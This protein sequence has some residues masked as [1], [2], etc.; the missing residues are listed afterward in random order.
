MTDHDFDRSVAERIR[1]YEARVAGASVPGVDEPPPAPRSSRLAWT[2]VVAAGGVA[3]GFALALA[4]NARIGPPVGQPTSSPTPTLEVSESGSPSPLPSEPAAATAPPQATG[5]LAVSRDGDVVLIRPDGTTVQQL[6]DDTG[7]TEVPVAWLLDGSALVVAVTADDNPYSSMLRLVSADG[8]ESTELGVV[9]P[10]YGAP[11]TSPDGQRI[12]FGGDGGASGGIQVLDLADGNLHVMTDDG[13][14]AP[15]WSPD[16]ELIAYNAADGS[17]TDVHVV[18]AD[19]SGPPAALAPDPAQ[20][21]V[22]RWVVSDGN[23]KIVFESWR[24]TDETKFAARP[25][26][27]NADGTEIQ[28]LEESGLDMDL[29]NREP[30]SVTSPDGEWFLTVH[31]TGAFVGRDPVAGDERLLPDTQGWDVAGLSPTFSP[32]G[33]FLAYSHAAGGEEPRYVVAIVV[34][35]PDDPKPIEPEIITTGAV[36]ESSPAWRPVP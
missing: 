35:T 28:L 11:S 33:R 8:S 30:P 4:L 22:I 16:G 9:H 2:L 25:W 29:A 26:V 23:L 13:G 32:D 24:G 15:L 36:S 6:T 3:A 17:G 34:L 1:A 19:G 18:A 7:A 21:H 5:T 27:M 12:A 20:D 10:V 14:T 31:P